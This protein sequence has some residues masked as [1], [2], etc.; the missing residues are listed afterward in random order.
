M[1]KNVGVKLAKCGSGKRVLIRRARS[2]YN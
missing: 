1:G 2:P